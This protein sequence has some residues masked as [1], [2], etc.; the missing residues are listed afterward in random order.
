MQALEKDY[1]MMSNKLKQSQEAYWQ[2]NDQIAKLTSDLKD[3][4]RCANIRRTV[5]QS[6]RATGNRLTQ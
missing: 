3:A 4:N 6:F 5:L 2:Q 1:D